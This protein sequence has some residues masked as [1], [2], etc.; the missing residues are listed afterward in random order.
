MVS[1]AW[2]HL[3]CL[4]QTLTGMYCILCTLYKLYVHTVHAWYIC[5]LY[6]QV[7]VILSNLKYKFT[8]GW[9]D[10]SLKTSTLFNPL[11][12]T[13]RPV[14]YYQES[15]N[16]ISHWKYIL[17]VHYSTRACIYF[18]QNISL[19]FPSSEALVDFII[20]VPLTLILSA[21]TGNKLPNV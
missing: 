16:A 9:H 7:S 8:L 17:T 1:Y 5:K 13:Y 21:R 20:T 19:K 10:F 4:N 18:E 2:K 14:L 12:E 6:N 11:K 15:C 3:H